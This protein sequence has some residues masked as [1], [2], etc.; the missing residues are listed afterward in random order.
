MC[1]LLGAIARR[2]QPLTELLAD[3]L[4]PFTQLSQR[5]CDGW[6]VA[7]WNP[8]GDLVTEK[9]PE[10]A[11]GSAAFEATIDAATTDAALL[12]LRRASP[13]MPTDARNTHPFVAGSIAMAHNGYSYPRAVL[14]TLLADAHGPEPAGD[15]DSERY[16]GLIL[17]AMR[18][19][20]PV[21]AIETAIEA[22]SANAHFVSLNCLLLTNEALYAAVRF[23]EAL[24]AAEGE[25]PETYTLRFRTG[26]DSVIVASSGWEQSAPRWEELT[27]GQVLEVGRRDL[28]ATVHRIGR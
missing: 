22:I 6:G 14:D 17:A 3:D 12:H 10:A 25:T 2:P 8:H 4:K 1:R 28:R 24:V 9:R 19:S 20:P 26:P 18:D 5:H 11:R 13:G 27:N 16:F 15:T 23:D 7:Y 21:S